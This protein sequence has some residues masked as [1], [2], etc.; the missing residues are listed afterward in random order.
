MSKYLFLCG[1]VL[2]STRIVSAERLSFDSAADW[3]TWEKPY[4]LVQVGAD[5]QLQLIKYRKNTDV[6]ADAPLFTHPSKTRGDAVP[7]GI[8]EAGSGQ[9]TADRVIDGDPET[10]WKPNPDDVVGEWFVQIDLG[11]AVLAKEIRITFPD[12]EGARPFRQ[13]TVFIATGATS[14]PLDDL[15]L[16]DPV[17]RTTRPNEKTEI[18]IPLV[19]TS[20]DTSRVLDPNLDVDLVEKNQYRLLQYINFT[21]EALDPEGALAE[22]EVVGVGDNVSIDVNRRGFVLDG[23]TSVSNNN[24][25]DAN[26]NT[27]NA[28][29]PV[30]FSGRADT[31]QTQGTWFYV[32]LGAIFWLDGAFIYVLKEQEGTAG[33]IAG[34]ARGFTIL[35]SDGTR[36]I[37]TDLPVPEPFDF[38]EL[39]VQPDGCPECLHYLRYQFRPR[40]IRYLFWHVHDTRGWNSK[41]AELMLFSPGHPAEVTMR[42]GFVDLGEVAGD[43]R[44]KVIRGLSWD[45]DLPPGARLQLRSRSGNTLNQVYDFYDRKGDQVTEEKWNSSP[46]VLRGP[47]DTM[48]VVGEDWDAWSEEYQFLGEAFKSQ[49]PRRFVQLELVLSTDDPAVGPVVN[50]LSVDFEDA[51]L[52]SAKGSIFPRTARPNE[53]TRFTYTLWPSA[54]TEDSGFDRLRFVLAEGVDPNSVEVEIGGQAITPTSV[55]VRGDS[56]LV[57][58]PEPVRND[59]LR[60]SFTTRVL[61][62]ATVFALDLGSSA[63]PGIWQSVEAAERRAN[64]VMLPELTGSGQLIVDLQMPDVFTPNGDGVND[65]LEVRFVALKVEGSAAEVAVYDLAGRRQAALVPGQAGSQRIYTWSGRNDAG[66]LVEPGIYLL[67]I[68]LGADAGEDIA[69]RSFSVAY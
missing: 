26:M 32:D 31:W 62:N 68:D 41:W 58:L 23:L 24:L 63:R 25:F 61:Q 67:R 4:G 39:L 22:I 48:V 64:I 42:S 57:D 43:G 15:F 2:L 36:A 38:N 17:Y 52:Q 9:A 18:S 69:L 19:F 45:A 14:D 47:I 3:A 35:A 59:S 65:R 50:A 33:F 55:E 13:F 1:L 37:G 8:W 30:T 66:D 20:K 29:A 46:K 16:F 21:V 44:P 12:R 49:S 7:G 56:L 60:A 6:I 51:F 53:E 54:E 28:I 11:R 27:N 40:R 10:F 34:S 5:G